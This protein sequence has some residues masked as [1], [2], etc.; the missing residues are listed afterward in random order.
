MF[1]KSGEGG[2]RGV[3]YSVNSAESEWGMFLAA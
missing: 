1:T 3:N 2:E